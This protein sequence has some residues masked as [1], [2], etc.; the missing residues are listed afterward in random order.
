MANQEAAQRDKAAEDAAAGRA[1]ASLAQQR[2]DA[3]ILQRQVA[4]NNLFNLLSQAPDVRGQKVEVK[5]P[6]AAKIGYTYDW[7]SIFANPQQ[8]KMFLT[9]YARGGQV[10][11]DLADEI[12]NLFNR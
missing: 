4:E 6:E 5:T 2:N 11:D 3:T 1:A 9:P 10:H 7:S 12:M 8:E